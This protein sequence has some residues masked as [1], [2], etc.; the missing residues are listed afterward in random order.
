MPRENI[1][2]CPACGFSVKAGSKSCDFCGYE[3]ESNDFA[4]PNPVKT[5]GQASAM[6]QGASRSTS[7]NGT[8]KGSNNKKGSKSQSRSN[9]NGKNGNSRK[10]RTQDAEGQAG[11]AVETV[12]V[13]DVSE[14]DLDP[15]KRI[16]ELE[17]QLTDA[18]KELD[19]ISKL[20]GPG[21]SKP[22]Q[23]VASAAATAPQVKVKQNPPPVEVVPSR[24]GARPAAA[25][26]GTSGSFA[27]ASSSSSSPGARLFFRFRGMTVGAIV[28]GLIVYALSFVLMQ[29]IGQLEMYLLILPASI[30]VALG[31]YASLEAS[32]ASQR[33]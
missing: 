11:A 13:V 22:E 1:V 9:G 16:K 3:F 6:G 23:A 15:Q 18:E 28:I 2:N 20:L 14:P 7:R 33:L 27:N 32:P 12:P 25:A 24:V 4:G 26:Q 30:L 21:H 19:E 8:R 5:A 29:S 17:K 10:S 31:L